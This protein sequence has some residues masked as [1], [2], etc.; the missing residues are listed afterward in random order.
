M[1]TISSAFNAL[2]INWQNLQTQE[3]SPTNDLDI[4]SI[5]LKPYLEVRAL[6]NQLVEKRK[7]NIIKDTL[8]LT[9]HPPTITLGKRLELEQFDFSSFTKQGI[10]VQKT[11]RGGELTFHAPGQLVLYPVFDLRQRR[12]GVEKF[13]E[14]FLSVISSALN[15]VGI[16]S[17]CRLRPAGL[18]V[19]DAKIASVGLRIDRGVT[20]HG[21]SLNLS[22]ALE[23]FSLFPV[24][25]ESKAKI[26]SV[27]ELNND[28]NILNLLT[29][30]LQTL[31]L[32][33]EGGMCR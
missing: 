28:A 27:L 18:W 4:L 30:K 29:N 31:F 14:V 6:Q 12:L 25:G 19:G 16:E 2:P 13:V 32:K 22:C 3:S 8:I 5:G 23:P 20:N 26:T 7:Q 9:E 15:E 21:F 10:E 11:D 1:D 24:C 33:F 17:K